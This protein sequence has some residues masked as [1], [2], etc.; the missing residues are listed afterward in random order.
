MATVR[1][2]DIA[3][4]DDLDLL[5]ID[6]QGGELMVFQVG[7]RRLAETVA[8]HTEV[9]FV[10]LYQDQPTIGDVDAELRLQGFLPHAMVALKRWPLAPVVYDGDFRRP[11][12]Q[13][14]E[15]DLVYVR[16]VT[17]PDRLTPDQLRHLAL[18]AHHVYGSSDL[19]HRCLLTLARRS[20][21]T[22]S[23]PEAYLTSLTAD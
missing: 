4:L 3:E 15:A 6:V 22:A 19:A 14:L 21:V 7:R 23:G 18:I 12:H 8:V 16:D 5:K 10:G 17:H 9:S 20:I 2:D 13:L 1:L 11:M